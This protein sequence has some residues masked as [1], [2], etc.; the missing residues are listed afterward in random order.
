MSRERAALP[1]MSMPD[2]FAH[3]D[4]MLKP[5]T[6]RRANLAVRRGVDTEERESS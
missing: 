2:I 5:C 4:V 1:M 3:Q 6:F